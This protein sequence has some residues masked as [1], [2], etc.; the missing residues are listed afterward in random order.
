MIRIGW[1]FISDRWLGLG[2]LV[3]QF[4]SARFL[5]QIVFNVLIKWRDPTN[6]NARTFPGKKVWKFSKTILL[7]LNIC[8]GNCN[9]LTR[10]PRPLCSSYICWYRN[11]DKKLSI[12]FG[13]R[14]K[15]SRASLSLFERFENLPK[16]F[17]RRNRF[18][19]DR[20][21]RDAK[22]LCLGWIPGIFGIWAKNSNP[23]SQGIGWNFLFPQGFSVI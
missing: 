1:S 10:D 7:S 20:L 17:S 4:S 2:L 13:P 18:G 12:Y 23:N 9:T 14:S 15:F 16:A 6:K 22:G 8:Q 21:S 3:Q 11:S 19:N 5:R